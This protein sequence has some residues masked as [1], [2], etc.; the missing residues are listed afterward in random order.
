MGWGRGWLPSPSPLPTQKEKNTPHKGYGFFIKL[1]ND[2]SYRCDVKLSKYS[3][4]TIFSICS[5]YIIERHIRTST[6][7][8]SEYKCTRWHATNTHTNY[9]LTEINSSISINCETSITNEIQALTHC[10]PQRPQSFWSA[11][12]IKTSGQWQFWACVEYLFC[13]F[14]PIKFLRFDNESVNHGLLVLGV[15]GCWQ[16]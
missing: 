2:T 3:Y 1:Y 5:A 14:L 7:I 8:C 11:P 10:R 9:W 15:A 16:K 13:N 4:L 12:R 6:E